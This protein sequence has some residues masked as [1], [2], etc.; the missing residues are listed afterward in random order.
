MNFCRLPVIAQ[1]NKIP[2]RSKLKSFG[3]FLSKA[4]E[5]SRCYRFVI[6]ERTK[7]KIRFKEVLT[8]IKDLERSLLHSANFLE[9]T[10]SF[11]DISHDCFNDF[12][13]FLVSNSLES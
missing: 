6:K 2:H 1:T 11:V 12:H 9:Y 13:S 10:D 3:K 4:L 7:A 5:R 8:D